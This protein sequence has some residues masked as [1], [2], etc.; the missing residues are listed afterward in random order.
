MIQGVRAAELG[1]AAGLVVVDCPWTNTVSATVNTSA[2][3]LTVVRIILRD[4]GGRL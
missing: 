4:N 1:E 3:S 2:K